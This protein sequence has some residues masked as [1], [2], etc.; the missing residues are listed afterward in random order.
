MQVFSIC[1]S[2]LFIE[3]FGYEKV[4]P[5]NTGAEAVETALKLAKRWATLKKGIPRDDV[6]VIV[7]EGNF[8]GRTIGIVSMSSGNKNF[9]FRNFN[10]YKNLISNWIQQILSW[11]FRLLI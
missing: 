1:A 10:D 9:L 5:M 11:S 3:Y 6:K 4:L 7:A 2:Y 8:H